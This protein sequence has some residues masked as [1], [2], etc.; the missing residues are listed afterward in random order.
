MFCE[1]YFSQ[2]QNWLI[3]FFHEKNGAKLKAGPEYVGG[4]IVSLFSYFYSST[5]SSY[6]N[7]KVLLLSAVHTQNKFIVCTAL[8]S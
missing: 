3:A 4:F 5:K 8:L 1:L 2:Q 7:R 6:N